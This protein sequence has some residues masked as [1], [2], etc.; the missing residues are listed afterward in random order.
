MT[1]VVAGDVV[2][3]LVLRR[4]PEVVILQK[5]PFRLRPAFS[6][7]RRGHHLPRRRPSFSLGVE[8]I[9]HRVKIERVAHWKKLRIDVRGIR[10]NLR[11]PVFQIRRLADA[12]A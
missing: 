6:V 4:V 8:V 11:V 2:A 5:A 7:G 1:S 10:D 3:P 9:S 12:D